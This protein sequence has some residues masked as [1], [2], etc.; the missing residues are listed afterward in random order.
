MK[1]TLGIEFY[2][3]TYGCALNTSDSDI[4]SSRLSRL[5]HS[6]TDTIDDADVLII[7][8]CGVKEPTEDK[9]IAR[10]EHLS[11]VNSPVIVGG[12]LPRI[13]LD[14]IINAIPNY[15][16]IVGPQSITTLVSILERVI[17][18]E[19][20]IIHLDTDV[21]SKL[22]YF[23]GPPASTIVTVPIAEGCL[24]NCTYCAVKFARNTLRS[25]EINEI[26]SVVKRCVHLGYKE[27]RLT[28]QDTGAF[29]RDTS[30]NLVELLTSVE[31]IPGEHRIRLGMFNPNLVTDSIHKMLQI[32]KSK[33]FYEFYHIPLQSGN[34]Q[35]LHEMNRQYSVQEWKDTV[36]AIRD[37]FSNAT[38]AT[39]IIVGYPGETDVQFLDTIELIQDVKP[40][41]VNISKYG[42]RPNTKASMS[43]EKVDTFVKKER[44]R[45]LTKLVNRLLLEAN[46]AMLGWT[47][48]V[49]IT[50]PASRGGS[51]ARTQQY[52]PV[53][54]EKSYN[55]GTWIDV[56][57]TKASKSYILGIEI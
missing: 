46:S 39:D 21:D 27:I 24:G 49:L 16:A 35:I 20:G 26:V 52:R 29:G 45:S 3:E 41:V 2:I 42:D 31:A 1:P 50:E 40:T 57:I 47:G 18:G 12:C 7:N 36:V 48:R 15:A 34:D 11:S 10:L 5:G 51:L 55:P 43:D 23:E 33:K 32:M 25:Y 17:S 37:S 9:I 56:E 38:I 8:T 13:S 22:K 4:I 6:R 19:Q 30:T 14:R 28:A 54:I 44:S 53:I